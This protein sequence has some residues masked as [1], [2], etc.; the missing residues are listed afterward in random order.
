[1]AAVIGA[2][3]TAALTF[4]DDRAAAETL[5]AVAG[6]PGIIAA[7]VYQ[8]GGVVFARYLRRGAQSEVAGVDDHQAVL[9]AAQ[10]A[11]ARGEIYFFE[12]RFLHLL[13]PIRLQGETIGTVH[14][15]DDLQA[16]RAEVRRAWAIA[17]GVLL[18]AFLAA[19]VLSSRLH[20]IISRPVLHLTQVM[21]AVSQGADYSLRAQPCGKDELGALIE[22][23]ND[24]L[25][26]VQERDQ[27]LERYSVDLEQRVEERT[28]ELRRSNE[29]LERAVA[30]AQVA[31]ERAEAASRAKSQFLANMSHEIR[32]PMNGVLGMAELLLSS[33]LQDRQ[34]RYAET[35]HRSGRSLL[36][37][38]NDILDFSKVEAGRLELEDIAFD[39]HAAVE[40]ATEFFAERVYQKG[41]EL[42]CHLHAMVP[43]RVRGDPGRLQQVLNNLIGNA[44]KFTQRGDI[45]V[46]VS[47]IEDED[48]D[49][50]VLRFEI[51]DTGIGLGAVDRE[52]RF[53]AFSQA[54]GSTTRVYGGTGL[55][56]AIS[57]QLVR[58]QGGE[59][60]VSSEL[61]AGSTFW[62]TVRLALDSQG[63][64]SAPES[65][66][67]LAR[68][69]ALRVL[70]AEPHPATRMLLA[71]YLRGWGPTCDLAGDAGTAAAT[72][73]AA[74]AAGEPYD[75]LVVD[76][77]MA[78]AQELLALTVEHR[79]DGPA[80]IVLAPM[81]AA[82]P[83]MPGLVRRVVSKPVRRA[84]LYEALLG[85]SGAPGRATARTDPAADPPITAATPVCAGIRVLLVEDNGV[86]REVAGAMLDLLGCR[87]TVVGNGREAVRECAA[88]Q[89]D[90]VLMDC[91]M[92]EMDGFEATRRIREAEAGQRG[93]RLPIV[94][95]T[96][97]AMQ[98]DRAH[99]LAAGMDDYLS[100]PFDQAQLREVLLRWVDPPRGAALVAEVAS[101]A[102]APVIAEGG[103][104]PEGEGADLLDPQALEAIRRLRRPGGPDLLARVVHIYLDDAPALVDRLAEALDAG[105]I[106]TFTRSAHTLKSSSANLGAR[107]LAE[108]CRE[109]ELR[110]R[111]GQLDGTR[112]LL[113][114]VR[115]RV[116]STIAALAGLLNSAPAAAREG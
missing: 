71:Q 91:Q 83:A 35:I 93:A 107:A 19:L 60:G 87:V 116:G 18:V 59:I 44:V 70:I 86:N 42:T 31:R 8:P 69:R 45:S 30:E 102:G 6:K 28:R 11:L 13:H 109:L 106:D 63:M 12:G 79:S 53:E 77:S 73:A 49:V 103:A 46:R 24:M 21:S 38:I 15:V 22:G 9:Q 101:G 47:R 92:P 52:R 98:G 36:G 110:G 80:L 54:D 82:V 40:E 114:E 14:L 65:P 113:A 25:Q 115:R 112:P 111:A 29:D 43:A 48:P 7:Q 88:G 39:L 10:P 62:F 99:C 27:A 74:T 90:V 64:A 34:R 5:A 108:R 105:D 78:G 17:A 76:H 58:L 50:A 84:H 26:Q 56:L 57:R 85:V 104:P 23:F 100:K 32:T 3:S 55:G 94:A 20:R 33:R 67:P 66:G 2:N 96:A 97:N 81:A 75:V 89:Y 72:L 51:A 4:G 68:L 61:G 16:L 1:V 37:I 41:L 95:L